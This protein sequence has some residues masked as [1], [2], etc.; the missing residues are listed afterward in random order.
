MR[1]SQEPELLKA[2]AVLQRA[3]PGQT[4]PA[5][6]VA[7]Y[8]EMLADLPIDAVR[9]AVLAIIRQRRYPTLPTVGE[10]R[11]EA[12]RLSLRAPSPAE[13]VEE[14]RQQIRGVGLW[15][16]PQFSHPLV[17]RAVEAADW[18]HLCMSEEPTRSMAEFRRLY[19]D[20]LETWTTRVQTEGASALDRLGLSALP[21]PTA[22][23]PAPSR[24][25][26]EVR[27]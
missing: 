13:A 20:L 26:R 11:L 16:R 23:L 4:M 2:I 7:L 6:T 14:V 10:I 9:A 1:P 19:E 3:F 24:L 22:G 15:G 8:A 21:E 12:A 25:R 17:A 18:R 5:D 27:A